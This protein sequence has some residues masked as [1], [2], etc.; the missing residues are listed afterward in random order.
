MSEDEI[1]QLRIRQDVLK[2]LGFIKSPKNKNAAKMS[3]FDNQ[4]FIK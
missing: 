3:I 4:N 1:K 2:Q